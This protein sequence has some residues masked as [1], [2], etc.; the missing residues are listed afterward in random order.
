M[1]KQSRP[2]QDRIDISAPADMRVKLVAIAYH[3]GAAGTYA[4]PARNF[5]A[6]GI[7]RYI[8]KLEGR[9]KKDFEEILSNVKLQ[10]MTTDDLN[11]KP[12]A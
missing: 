10:M 1:T 12:P 2:F 9:Q 7:S 5:I 3:M 11:K 6:E 4:T 8:D